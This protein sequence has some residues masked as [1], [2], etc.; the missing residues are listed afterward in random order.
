MLSWIQLK[1]LYPVHKISMICLHFKH[2]ILN[3]HT[4]IVTIRDNNKRHYMK[5]RF[6]LTSN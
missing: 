4:H 5:A 1:F 2:K 3:F 6:I